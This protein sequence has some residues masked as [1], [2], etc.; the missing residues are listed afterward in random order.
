MTDATQP[1]Y[2]DWITT[3][4]NRQFAEAAALDA[5]ELAPD[6]SQTNVWT[7]ANERQIRS[8]RARPTATVWG[9]MFLAS[10]AFWLCATLLAIWWLA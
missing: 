2:G 3:E 6:L 1:V 10:A 9:W 4:R 5:Q 7:Q 8:D